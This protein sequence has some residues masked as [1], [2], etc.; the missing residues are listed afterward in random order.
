MHTEGIFDK[1][2]SRIEKEEN[3]KQEAIQKLQ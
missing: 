3:E 2:A 1:A